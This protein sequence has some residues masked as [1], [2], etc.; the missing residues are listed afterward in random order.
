[1][2]LTAARR[3]RSLSFSSTRL[4]SHHLIYWDIKTFHKNN[5]KNILSEECK[6]DEINFRKA[7]SQNP[8]AV[9]NKYLS[10]IDLYLSQLSFYGM[11]VMEQVPKFDIIIIT[12]KKRTLMKALMNLV[13]YVKKI[14]QQM[15]KN[16]VQLSF[17]W[18]IPFS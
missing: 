3:I 17:F 12:A 6:Y 9:S 7:S 1:M 10:E 16:L 2:F 5:K 11:F 18:Q 8:I 14:W 15:K 4:Y 13:K